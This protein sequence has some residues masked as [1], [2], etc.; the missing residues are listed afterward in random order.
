MK[1]S[2]V[3]S[4][5]TTRYSSLLEKALCCS[6]CRCCRIQTQVKH[7]YNVCYHYIKYIRPFV[8]D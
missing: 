4:L 2:V 8:H 5:S 3:M 1:G 7:Y 6:L